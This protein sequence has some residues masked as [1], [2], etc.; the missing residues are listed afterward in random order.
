MTPVDYSLLLRLAKPAAMLIL[1]LLIWLHG[2]RHGAAEKDL[3][4]TAKWNQH[5]AADEQAYAATLAAYQKKHDDDAALIAILEAQGYAAL[6]EKQRENAALRAAVDAGRVRLRVKA[7]CPQMPAAP[8][9]PQDPGLGDGAAAE[10]DPAARQDYLDLRAGI[11][12][13]FQQLT[14]CQAMLKGLTTP[15]SP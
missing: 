13:Q 9:T 2:D 8:G 6:Q 11:G 5:L 12:H 7:T 4:W 3:A 15:S 14:A 1:A 10:L